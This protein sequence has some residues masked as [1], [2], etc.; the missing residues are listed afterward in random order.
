[1][2]WSSRRF[3][4]GRH[5]ATPRRWQGSAGRAP[6]RP[7]AP[8]PCR[9]LRAP[10]GPSPALGCGVPGLACRAA[11]SGGQPAMKAAAPPARHHLAAAGAAPAG[12]RAAAG[13][14]PD[15]QRGAVIVQS[16]GAHLLAERADAGAAGRPV[17]RLPVLH[18]RTGAGG[19]AQAAKPAADFFG[20]VPG[21]GLA[22]SA[23]ASHLEMLPE[24]RGGR[25]G[26]ASDPAPRLPHPALR[27]AARAP[28]K[29]CGHG[30]P[31]KGSS[32]TVAAGD[33]A[34]G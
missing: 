28:D 18:R 26:G 21:E 10:D 5:T 16:A 13:T 27:P 7:A 22:V 6:V 3:R 31:G 8:T 12:A 11:R 19:R 14:Q 1:M 29:F 9:L 30:Q 4:Q 25:A 20:M 15:R 34:L 2:L 23:G 33:G 24:G 17:L 32:Q